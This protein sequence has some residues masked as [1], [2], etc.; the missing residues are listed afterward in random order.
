MLSEL[1]W[2][3]DIISIKK[4]INNYKKVIEFFKTRY[5]DKILD[6]DIEKLTNSKESEAKKVFEFCNLVW[7]KKYLNYYDNNKLFSKTL[8]FKQIR[9]KIDKYDDNKYKKYYH[10]I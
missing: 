5:P 6:L 1:S 7:D 2:A 10:L 9:S 4:Y 8:S 3:H